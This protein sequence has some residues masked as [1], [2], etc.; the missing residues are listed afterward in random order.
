MTVGNRAELFRMRSSVGNR[1][2]RFEWIELRLIGRGVPNGLFSGVPNGCMSV[3]SPARE[4][5]KNR[6]CHHSSN[7]IILYRQLCVKMVQ[8]LFFCV[9]LKR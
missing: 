3:S 5:T 7:E 8:G 6:L 2:G 4:G 1:P 9:A